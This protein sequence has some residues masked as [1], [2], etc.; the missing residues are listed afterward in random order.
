MNI[1]RK[2]EKNVNIE[3]LMM[4]DQIEI[5]LDGFGL[6]VATVQ[7]VTE[8]GALFMFD[9]CVTKRAMDTTRINRIKF[10]QTELFSWLN[11]TLINAFPEEIKSHIQYISIPSYGQIFGS[12]TRPNN[13]EPDED[14]Q[15]PLMQFRKNRIADYCNDY[16]WYWLKNSVSAAYFASVH[17]GGNATYGNASGVHGVRPV[18]L[19]A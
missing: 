14:V 10:E 2:E 7:T 17:G 12:Y 19:L 5:E 13:V 11:N 18:F 8:Q 16:E 15:F 3:D 4:G 6:F 1:I 9:D